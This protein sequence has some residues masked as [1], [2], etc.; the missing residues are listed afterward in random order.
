MGAAAAWA[1]TQSPAI[2]LSTFSA[3]GIGMALPYLLLS[4][5]PSLVKRMPRTGPA[6]E[7]IKQVMGLLLLA[8]GGYFLGTGLAGVFATPPDPPSSLYWW[9]VGLLVA[10]AGGWLLWRTIQL[11]KKF[12]QRLVFGGLGLLFIALGL[13]LSVKLT[14]GSPIAWTYYTP[15]RLAKAQQ[16]KKITVLEFTAAWCLNCH[17]LEQAVLHNPRVV[18]LLN[19]T[20]VAPIKVDITGNNIP[21][22]KK[23]LEVGSRTI[24]HL[25]VYAPDGREV[26]RSDA[27]TVEQ[28]VRAITEAGADLNALRN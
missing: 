12:Q 21:G 26:F 11:T 23:L 4:G 27:Y 16:A 19:S 24:P 3:I 17:A 8:A 9:L 28:L 10:A 25:V 2:T 13:L 18:K 22:S 6:S 1:T 14:R 5:F 15:E 7:L 20:N